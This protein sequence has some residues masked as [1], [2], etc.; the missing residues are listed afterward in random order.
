MAV[1]A[2]QFELQLPSASVVPMKK[3]MPVQSRVMHKNGNV[4]SS[5]KRRPKVSMVKKAGKAKT[6]F[7]MPVPMAN[8]RA[9]GRE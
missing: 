2:V 4:T 9:C 6:Q 1:R 7:R 3:D 8:S 5:K